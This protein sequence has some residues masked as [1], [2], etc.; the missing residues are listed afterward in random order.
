MQD[1][2]YDVR[3][4]KMEVYNGARV[5]TYTV[6]WKVGPKPWK[7][8]FRNKA[9]ADSFEAELRA[10]AKKGEAF[11]LTTGRP[12]AWQREDNDMSWYAFACKYVDMKWKDASAGYR[13]DIARALTAA[14]P[15][16]YA[17]K[18]GKPEDKEI[19]KALTRWAFNS[20]RRAECP[21]N[22][23]KILHW[24]DQNTKPMSTLNE[25]F[26]TSVARA[27]ITT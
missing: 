3:I 26:S 14:T 5:T 20:R 18:R 16:M 10:A 6:R 23:A 21:D 11:S 7:E 9:Q 24:L 22:V 12:V 15:A 8:P 1:I 4:Y 17:T 25:C 19:R 13:R 27:L 2:T